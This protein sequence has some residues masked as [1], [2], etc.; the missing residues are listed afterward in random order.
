MAKEGKSNQTSERSGTPLSQRSG[1]VLV[2][3]LH[4]KRSARGLMP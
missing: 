4:G 2:P 3:E 1:L